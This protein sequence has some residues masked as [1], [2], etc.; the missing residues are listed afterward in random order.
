MNALS[1]YQPWA[2]AFLHG[3]DVENRTWRPLYR[4][5]FYIHAARQRSAEHY[6]QV[7]VWIRRQTG[8]LVP[9]ADEVPY[10]GIVAVADLVDVVTTS[11]S[12]WFIGPFGWIVR[13]VRAVPLRP[14]R[15]RPRWFQVPA[16][17]AVVE[18]EGD[19]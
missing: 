6:A 3:K 17:L 16:R 11:A 12:P 9:A 15:G 14:C 19:E 18:M 1:V 5:T 2:W 10:G 7:A 13:N 4:G 8:L